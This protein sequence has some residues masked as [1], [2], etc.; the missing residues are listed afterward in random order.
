MTISVFCMPNLGY[1]HCPTCGKVLTRKGVREILE[2]ILALPDG[3]ALIFL[4]ESPQLVGKTE[5]EA[6]ALVN[7]WGY[8][9]VRFRGAD[10]FD[11]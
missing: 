2:E 11:C 10:H 7:T 6:L 3:M 5:K 4:A 1:P 8:V 9:R